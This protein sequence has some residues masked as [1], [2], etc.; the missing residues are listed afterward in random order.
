M[1]AQDLLRDIGAYLSAHRND[2][3]DARDETSQQLHDSPGDG[4]LIERRRVIGTL[5]NLQSEPARTAM[6]SGQAAAS[7]G[8]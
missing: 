7:V 1:S 2:L 8:Q 3:R 4:V 6:G 5:Q